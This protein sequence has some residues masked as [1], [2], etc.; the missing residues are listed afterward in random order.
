MKEKS[1]AHIRAHGKT[2][3]FWR[4]IHKVDDTW[5]CYY[6]LEEGYSSYFYRLIR[7]NNY[8]KYETTIFNNQQ[9]TA[10]VQT[11]EDQSFRIPKESHLYDLDTRPYDILSVYYKIRSL[12]LDTLREGQVLE[13][14]VFFE[15]LY[16][17]VRI[18]YLG[19]HSLETQL[20][21]YQTH[22]LSPI[23]PKNK[24][25]SGRDAVKIWISTDQ[26]RLP[27]RVYADMKLGSVRMDL[28]AFKNLRHAFRE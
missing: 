13:L 6:D 3:G 17:K 20:G 8:T 7:E 1:Y 25:F 24:V 21:K 15:D 11:Y 9:R 26:N 28:K 27:L 18:R 5:G 22:V 12:P 19:T 10:N 4:M 14:P 16:Y 23:F 2:R